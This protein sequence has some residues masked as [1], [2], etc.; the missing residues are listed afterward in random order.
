MRWIPGALLVALLPSASS[1][2]TAHPAAISGLAS[3]ARYCV[4]GNAANVHNLGWVA[5]QSGYTI[6]FDA[7]FTLA[8][9]VVRFEAVEHRATVVDGD[10]GFS[11]NASNS[12]TMVL[13]VTGNGQAGCYRYKVIVDPPAASI[14]EGEAHLRPSGRD[15]TRPQAAPAGRSVNADRP[16]GQA[17]R[18]NER[19]T[20]ITERR[21]MAAGP[22]AISGAPTSAQHCVAGSNVPNV[23][24]LG[25]VDVNRR[26]TVTFDTD[27]SA[28]V[29]ATMTSLEPNAGPGSFVV[30]PATG[31]SRTP[32]L[33]FDAEA[34]ENVVL[35]VAGF[36]GVA[37]CYKYKVEIR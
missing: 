8:T 15:A 21:A 34:G 35:Y 1:A 7:D 5:A 36:G 26:V 29:G 18:S 20:A 32:S 13:H 14:V 11:F 10:P 3:S 24:E 23:H 28:V 16:G 17:S 22:L 9:S 25:R 31:G 37:G 2:Q 6:T 33:A 12:G 19:V 30:D 27:F 4:S